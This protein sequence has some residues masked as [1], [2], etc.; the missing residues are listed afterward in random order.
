MAAIHR[1]GIDY[2]EPVAIIIKHGYFVEVTEVSAAWAKMW[3]RRRDS[4]NP[5]N[6]LKSL[7]APTRRLWEYY[8]NLQ[9]IR[10]LFPHFSKVGGGIE[11]DP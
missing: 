4:A 3:C 1:P 8:R 7:Y 2:A 11:N 5:A 9:P 10:N 6:Y